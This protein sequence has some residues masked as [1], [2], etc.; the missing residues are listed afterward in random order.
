[1]WDVPKKRV[2]VCSYSI[3]FFV[4]G[5]QWICLR[6]TASDAS[7]ARGEEEEHSCHQAAQGGR[8]E[9]VADH[10]TSRSKR[11]ARRRCQ[12]M[13]ASLAAN[14]CL[15]SLCDVPRWAILHLFCLH[16]SPQSPAVLCTDSTMYW[17]TG[18]DTSWMQSLSHV[19]DH[20]S[21]RPDSHFHDQ[22]THGEVDVTATHGYVRQ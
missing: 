12:P 21:G 8:R 15:C 14:F 2:L 10:Q 7:R 6:R 13:R 11:L 1:M 19:I 16:S 3:F 5:L 18:E 17:H 20:K 9:E 22:R 4:S